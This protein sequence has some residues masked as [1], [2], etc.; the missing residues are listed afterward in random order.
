VVA[1]FRVWHSSYRFTCWAPHCA[2]IPVALLAAAG[3]KAK[4]AESRAKSK[5]RRLKCHEGIMVEFFKGWRRKA[6]CLCLLMALPLAGAWVRSTTTDDA[7]RFPA[8]RRQH[9]VWSA[10]GRISWCAWELLE[11]SRTKWESQ[12][13][14]YPPI[15]ESGSFDGSLYRDFPHLD[16]LI[17]KAFAHEFCE[18]QMSYW[19]FVWP[20]T[21]L[22]IALLFWRPREPR[23]TS[24]R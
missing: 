5:K 15:G 17:D 8:F 4:G 21:A 10:R 11:S 12:P 23:E 20:L 14:W 24:L 1:R 7:I 18:W 22:S 13:L 16:Y 6:G 2:I 19:T 9:L 3:P